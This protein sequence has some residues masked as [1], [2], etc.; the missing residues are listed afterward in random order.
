MEK[1]EPGT[2]LANISVKRPI[3]VDTVMFLTTSVWHLPLRS[4]ASSGDRIRNVNSRE[5]LY[6]PGV[7]A[8]LIRILIVIYYYC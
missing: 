6:I 8:T 5:R 4:S 3:I 7:F 2:R 1:A